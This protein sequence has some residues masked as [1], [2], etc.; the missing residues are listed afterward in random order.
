MRGIRQVMVA[1][2]NMD[3]DYSQFLKSWLQIWILDPLGLIWDA[4]DV[5][6]QPCFT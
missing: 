3:A 2:A 5:E 1:R 4:L 6:Y